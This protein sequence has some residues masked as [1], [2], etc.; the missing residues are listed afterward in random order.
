[1]YR[2]NYY[3][4]N[5]SNNIIHF[6]IIAVYH[7]ENDDNSRTVTQEYELRYINA[8]LCIMYNTYIEY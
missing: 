4:Q 3:A 5:V 2:Y 7:I 8:I 6:L 1:M